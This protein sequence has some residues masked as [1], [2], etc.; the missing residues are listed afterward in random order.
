M[1]TGRQSARGVALIMVLWILVLL[2]LTVG[3]YSVLARTETLQSR[4]LFDV[5]E[6]RYAAEAGLHRAV[7]EMRNPDY[8]TR[9]VPDGRSYYMEFGNAVVEMQVTDESG[10]IDLNRTPA[11]IMA[12][13]FIQRGVEEETAWQLSDAI[14]DWR[15]PDDLP[16]LY[17][18][19]ID[20]YE[21]AGYPYGPANQEFQS[22]DE[23]QQVIG[24]SF[25][26]FQRL[27][28]F[29]TVHGR[30]G[31]VNPAFAPAEVLA[32]MPDMDLES[33]RLFVDE[34]HQ[35][36]PA[37]MAALM[38]PNGQ[39][40]NLQG[41][42]GVFSIRSRATLDNGAWTQIEATVRVGTDTRGR[43]FRIVRWREN[44][45]D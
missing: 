5:T 27:E 8:E 28:G 30:G 26:L 13:L 39:L 43:P 32:T 18:A 14:E 45:E 37:D 29:L 31:Q 22:V 35:S 2:T 15:D 7:F 10:R 33:A 40:V 20:E 44:I 16:R 41:G 21:A 25:E 9:W 42:G 34:R 24:V 1:R 38:L 36:H 6:A 19:E 4:F 12:E 3:V 23:L 11:E 17:G